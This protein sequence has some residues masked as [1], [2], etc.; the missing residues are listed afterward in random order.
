[1]F[2]K[3]FDNFQ[4]ISGHFQVLKKRKRYSKKGRNK[5]FFNLTGHFWCSRKSRCSSPVAS[6]GFGCAV[7]PLFYP[8]FTGNFPHFSYKEVPNLQKINLFTFI[9]FYIFLRKYRHVL[10]SCSQH[11]WNPKQNKAYIFT[12]QT[13]Q[14]VTQC[15]RTQTLYKT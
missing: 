12:K 15:H 7:N 9:L 10:P 5:V 6:N 1:M 4:V 11:P 8:A 2:F 3:I 14:K 13:F